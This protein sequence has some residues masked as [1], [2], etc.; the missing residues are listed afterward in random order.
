MLQMAAVYN[1]TY[2]SR[3]GRPSITKSTCHLT[4]PS[5]GTLVVQALGIK[6]SCGGFRALADPK[7]SSAASV[8]I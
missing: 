6:T 3:G 1:L 2:K 8:T 7:V 5:G 4:N